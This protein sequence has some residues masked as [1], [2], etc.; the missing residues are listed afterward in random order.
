MYED[1]KTY[2]EESTEIYVKQMT[3]A[4]NKEL[5]DSKRFITIKE[6][7]SMGTNMSLH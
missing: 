5:S 6:N 1:I 2:D 4:T 3:D 7:E